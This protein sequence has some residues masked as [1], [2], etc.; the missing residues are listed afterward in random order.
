VVKFLIHHAL[1][2][3]MPKTNAE[4]LAEYE[5]AET[6]VLLSQSYSISG[7]SVTRAN[8]NEIRK[9]IDYYSQMADRDTNGGITVR[10]ITPVG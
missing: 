5:A 2:F 6:A 10:G 8:L 1:G 9:A 3:F 7:R 4:R